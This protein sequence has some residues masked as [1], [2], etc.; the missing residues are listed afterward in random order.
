MA[1]YY[2]FLNVSVFKMMC[3]VYVWCTYTHIYIVC[4]INVYMYA[5][6]WFMYV[7]EGVFEL[8]VRWFRQHYEYQIQWYFFI[9]WTFDPQRSWV[10]EL[11]PAFWHSAILSPLYAPVPRPV[12]HI[13]VQIYSYQMARAC[14]SW[15]QQWSGLG[16]AGHGHYEIYEAPAD[17]EAY[18]HAVGICHR[19]IKPQNLLVEG[20]KL[21]AVAI[22][23]SKTCFAWSPT[24][25]CDSGVPD[26]FGSLIEVIRT[27]W[28]S[29]TSALPSR[30]SRVS[31][32]W[33]TFA[34]WRSLACKTV[35]RK[36]VSHSSSECPQQSTTRSSGQAWRCGIG[37][38]MIDH[39]AP[40]RSHGTCPRGSRYYRAP[41]LI[42]GATDYGFVRAPSWK[43]AQAECAL[44]SWCSFIL[45]H[46]GA[47]DR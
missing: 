8:F 35:C 26:L 11:V 37:F 21:R 32:M 6:L 29:A 33:L 12:P 42:F 36:C 24:N 34:A 15:L 2:Y 13:F 41:E 1:I 39:Q 44:P 22:L 28:K 3:N 7:Y 43:A 23:R 38:M 18:I 14:V 17:T 27:P 16:L 30:W 31:R 9:A 25:V 10:S 40:A 47:L 4:I 19:D 45:F 20:A 5:Y 46:P